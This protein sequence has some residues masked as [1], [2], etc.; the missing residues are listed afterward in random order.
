VVGRRAL[1]RGRDE[2]DQLGRAAKGS[3]SVA[4]NLAKFL[5]D[6]DDPRRAVEEDTRANRDTGR[7]GRQGYTGMEGLLNYLY[8][9][10]GAIN[11][12]DEVGH[13]LHFSIFEVGTGPCANYNAGEYDPDGPGPDPA[14][15]GVPNLDGSA[16]TTDVTQA[17]RC[18]AWLGDQQPGLSEHIDVPPYDPSVCPDGSDNLELCTPAGGRFAASSDASRTRTAAGSD[19]AAG[20]DGSLPPRTDPTDPGGD[21]TDGSTDEAPTS[22]TDPTAPPATDPGTTEEPGPNTID[23][24]LDDT[25]KGVTG[26]LGRG[27]QSNP[28]AAANGDLLGYLFGN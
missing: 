8:Y 4:D 1:L 15:E 14:E 7:K 10:T 9:Q 18:V 13:L 23:D 2:I 6:I 19:P 22:P 24:I 27:T 28:G 16:A 25:I 17:N 5:R 12:Y 11:Q 20:N 21:G 26:G 3:F